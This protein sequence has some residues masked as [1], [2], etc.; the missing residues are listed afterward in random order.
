MTQVPTKPAAQVNRRGILARGGLVAAAAAVVTVA[1][2]TD[3]EAFQATPAEKAA[4]Y[5]DSKHVQR[6]YALNRR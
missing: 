6:F 1:R 5:Q 2:A 4:R 3:A